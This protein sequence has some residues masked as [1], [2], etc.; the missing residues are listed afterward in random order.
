METPQKA[1]PIKGA[2]FHMGDAA[3]EYTVEN[4]SNLT[5]HR[6]GTQA[7]IAARL[8][9]F[10]VSGLLS[11]GKKRIVAGGATAVSA[12]VGE[13]PKGTIRF[14]F[15]T[16]V[17]PSSIRGGGLSGSAGVQWSENS[18]GVLDL[19]DG[20]VGVPISITNVDWGR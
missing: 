11:G 20:R 8:A 6:R 3:S 7:E 19:P 12:Y 5:Y 4:A 15:K 10:G 1:T 9:E 18:P 13:L 17:P 14:E 16:P 2:E